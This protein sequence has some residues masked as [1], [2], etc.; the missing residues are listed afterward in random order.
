MPRQQVLNFLEAKPEVDVWAA[1]ASLYHM[2]TGFVPRNFVRD[3]DPWWTV[4]N[5]EA[6]KIRERRSSI[7][8][9]LAEVIDH[10]LIDVPEIRIRSAVELKRLLEKAV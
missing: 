9:R 5:T 3:K 7:P 6:V 4:C 2:L 8:R 10:A 1:A